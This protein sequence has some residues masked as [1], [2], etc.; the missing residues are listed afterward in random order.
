[1][2]SS[3][4]PRRAAIARTRSAAS[5]VSRHD[6]ATMAMRMQAYGGTEPGFAMAADSARCLALRSF[7]PYQLF[8]RRLRR[9]LSLFLA[10]VRQRSERIYRRLVAAGLRFAGGHFMRPIGFRRLLLDLRL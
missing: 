7:S 1:M 9:L 10:I 6:G 2:T 8:R 5:S 4:S 3:Q